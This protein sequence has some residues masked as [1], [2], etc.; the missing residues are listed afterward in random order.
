MKNIFEKP[1]SYGDIL[2]LLYNNIDTRFTE[3]AV[4]EDLKIYESKRTKASLHK[5]REDNLIS[6]TKREYQT[7]GKTIEEDIFWINNEGIKFLHN[8][9]LTNRQLEIS[10]KSLITSKRAMTITVFA[11]LVQVVIAG[12]NY[13]KKNEPVII[14]EKHYIDT[15][16]NKSVDL[17]VKD[18]LVKKTIVNDTTDIN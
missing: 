12:F 18:F 3:L 14:I 10:N 4:I 11:I 7:Q 8:Q 6:S 1:S 5:L 16:S 15:T 13:F 17:M 9:I 2:L